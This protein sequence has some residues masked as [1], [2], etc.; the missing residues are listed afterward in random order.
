M[1]NV[2]WPDR[3]SALE[4]C[5]SCKDKNGEAAAWHTM[6][7]GRWFGNKPFKARACSGASTH[8]EPV[9]LQDGLKAA[10]EA[11][12][13]FEQLGHRRLEAQP[14]RRN[15]PRPT[16]ESAEAAELHSI[17]DWYHRKGHGRE[18]LLYAKD[19]RECK[20]T[21]VPRHF[22]PEDALALFAELGSSEWAIASRVQ[23]SRVGSK[24]EVT[25]YHL[26]SST[27]R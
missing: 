3:A 5:P 17:A 20:P 18:G 26:T 22:V 7:V 4:P 19:W 10:R 27:V 13:L 6:A 21:L 8:F 23:H 24:S 14:R 12:C 9:A 15:L 1:P 16:R 25:T 2:K 11:L